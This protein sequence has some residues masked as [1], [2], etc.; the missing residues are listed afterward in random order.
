VSRSSNPVIRVECD[1]CCGMAWDYELEAAPVFSLGYTVWD[2]RK[3]ER[4][5]ERDGWR[6][7]ETEAI[8]GLCV[9]KEEGEPRLVLAWVR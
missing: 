5:I 4:E 8:C 1:R 9:Q 7:T 3:A 2:E 6:I